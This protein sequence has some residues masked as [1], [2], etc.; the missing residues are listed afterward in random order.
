MEQ[1]APSD[2]NSPH[3]TN[4]VAAAV[5][6]VAAAAAAVGAT[7]PPPAVHAPP[8]L[9][10]AQPP[11]AA[12]GTA[13]TAAAA[14]AGA[15]A[16]PTGGGGG[17]TAGDM[18]AGGGGEVAAA[19]TGTV[20]T[21][22]GI[23]N[24]VTASTGVEGSTGLLNPALLDQHK[25]A[26]YAKLD[27]KKPKHMS[28]AEYDE[29]L[30]LL[31]S[32]TDGETR[33]KKDYYLKETCIVKQHVARDMA[34]CRKIVRQILVASAIRERDFVPPNAI[35]VG[36]TTQIAGCVLPAWSLL[37]GREMSA[38]RYRTERGT[39]RDSWSSLVNYVVL[40]CVYVSYL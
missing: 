21:T 32:W 13:G 2:T 35:R 24:V 39:V 38:L 33:S 6:A 40:F 3:P 30:Q 18:G 22:S 4:A 27:N 9:P 16:A 11:D 28:R 36:V 31:E 12:T 20:G 25:S 17:T 8:P 29:S 14:G 23:G 26:F 34:L 7:L 5:V 15:G 19:A 1:N 37:L 10:P